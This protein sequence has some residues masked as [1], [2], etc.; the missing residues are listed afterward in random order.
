MKT[1]AEVLASLAREYKIRNGFYAKKVKAGNMSQEEADHELQC[2]QAAI[3][4]VRA[5][6]EPVGQPFFT[7]YLAAYQLFA[8]QVLN[9]GAAP[10][11]DAEQ[12]ALVA[13]IKKME[14]MVPSGSPEEALLIWQTILT[15]ECWN[16]LSD[17]I[18]QQNTLPQISRNLQ[19]IVTKL[20]DAIS[21]KRSGATQSFRD[22][23][24]GK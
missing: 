4:M 2:T 7:D 3:I 19:E 9:L 1:K 18:R 22:R 5:Y 10:I 17:F 11:G 21:K 13:I 6:N 8:K 14:T 24:A 15:A 23:Y 20:Q 16:L 12:A